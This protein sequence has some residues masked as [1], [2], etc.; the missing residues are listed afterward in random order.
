MHVFP[1][2]NV[3]TKYHFWIR[4][5]ATPPNL[6]GILRRMAWIGRKYIL[7]WYEGHQTSSYIIVRTCSYKWSFQCGM[8]LSEKYLQR[9]PS[10]YEDFKSDPAS[11]KKKIFE[12]RLDLS[13]SCILFL[14]VIHQIDTRIRL[15]ICLSVWLECQNYPSRIVILYLKYFHVKK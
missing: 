8:L 7:A 12:I 10:S 4:I 9:F 3:Q 2:W 13:A 1:G 14:H 11:F 5:A 6:S 15:H